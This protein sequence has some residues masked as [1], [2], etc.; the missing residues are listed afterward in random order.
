MSGQLSMFPQTTCEDSPKLTSSPVLADGLTPSVSPD[1]LTI[2]KSGPALA[3]VSRSASPG[4]DLG[5]P[6]QGTCGRTFTG[7][8]P[9]ADRL[10]YLANR[11]VE[12]L[13]MVGS[14]EFSL[15]WRKKA[16]PAK[17]SIYRL[18]PLT[19]RTSDSGS[20]GSQ[21]TWG[22]PTV[23][24]ARHATLSPAEQKRAPGNLWVQVYAA[25]WPT[26]RT[27]DE[28]NGRG[29]TGN[30]SPEAAAKA[31]WTLPEITRATWLTPTAQP[32]NGDGESFLRRKGRKP[33]GAITDLGALALS[34]LTQSGSPEQTASRGAL[35]PEFPCW[36]MGYPPEWD[37][38][39]PTAM[40]SSRNSRRKS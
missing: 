16:T 20:I 27:S 1:G 23:Q 38:C 32:S 6:I 35:N 2:K 29:K 28:K 8:L 36:L 15:I 33:D 17:A 13:G 34:G 14:T 22:T 3:R 12:R 9:P 31:G 25:T 24:A 26:P 37:A 18:A 19:R 39:A 5:Q 4:K 40:P 7:S 21:A 30:R 10:S 11:L